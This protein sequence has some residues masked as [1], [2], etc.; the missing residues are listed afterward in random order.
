VDENNFA[1]KGV[2]IIH[3]GS[4]G[5]EVIFRNNFCEGLQSLSRL[6]CSSSSNP[7]VKFKMLCS[8][9]YLK[10]DTRIGHKNILESHEIVVNNEILS[11]YPIFFLQE[12][13]D[14]GMA[15][16][17]GNTVH[18]DLSRVLYYTSPDGIIYYTDAMGLDNNIQSMS[19]ICCNNI[20]DNVNIGTMYDYL[21]S[22][23]MT[24]VHKKN[25]FADT[26]EN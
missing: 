8:D 16:F 23:T 9:N 17:S 15:V 2:E 5:G 25:V 19:L 3:C 10:G 24:T 21:Q 6:S 1:R 4:K 12:F 13:A 7:I 22:N 11:D 14:S 26:Y 18:R 20:F